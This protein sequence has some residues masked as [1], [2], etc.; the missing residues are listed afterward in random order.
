MEYLPQLVI[1]KGKERAMT[2][3]HPWIYSGAVSHIPDIENGDLVEVVGHDSKRIG[4]G[5]YA[6]GN[7]IVCRVFEY[8]RDV[9]D[10]ASPAFWEEKIRKAYDLRK[11]LV[12][13][14]QTNSYRLIHAEG[15]FFPGLI[16][17]VYQDTVVLQLLIKGTEKIADWIIAAL[18][19]LGFRYIYHKSK[20]VSRRIE[21]LT[22]PKGWMTEERESPIVDMLENGVKFRV[23]VETGQKTG[24]FIDQRD[25]RALLS[26]YSSGKKVLNTFSYS[27]GF[28]MYALKAGA[29]EVHSVDSSQLAVDL[30]DENAL[31]NGFSNEQHQGYCADVFDYLKKMDDDYDVVILDPPAF[32]KTAKA[33]KNASRGYKQLNLNAFRKIKPGGI[34]FTFS[35]SQKI[36]RDLFR[37]IVFGA[38]A[39]AYRNIRI[40]HQTTQPP[41]HPINIYHPENEYLKGLVLYVE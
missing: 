18:Q 29:R 23:N 19:K 4:Y 33:V 27:G 31:L 20:D 1:K 24:F 7:Q 28:S 40:L 3:R 12:I 30:C 25:A 32:A 2:N 21:G 16:A 17:D 41:D 9:I 26:E 10:V 36:D 38:A 39:D 8:T 5:F 22:I 13:N 15:D 37:K 6:P 34:V 14:E 35:C 11:R